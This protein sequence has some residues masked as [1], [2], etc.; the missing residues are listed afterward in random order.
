[1]RLCQRLPTFDVKWNTLYTFME[2]FQFFLDLDL[3]STGGVV[4][5]SYA[6]E[7]IHGIRVVCLQ[8]LDL[9]MIYLEIFLASHPVLVILSHFKGVFYRGKGLNRRLVHKM[10]LIEVILQIQAKHWLGDCFLLTEVGIHAHVVL[11]VLTTDE[12]L[13][14]HERCHA[15][16]ESSLASA[17]RLIFKHL[18]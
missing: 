7:P 16:A 11:L 9:L 1:M 8:L 4:N 13:W 10:S 17:I 14:Q 18:L 5:I 15:R 2:L 6:L 3:E 12:I